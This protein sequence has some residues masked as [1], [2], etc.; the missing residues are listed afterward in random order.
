MTKCAAGAKIYVRG[1]SK[2]IKFNKLPLDLQ[3]RI[4][5]MH[6]SGEGNRNVSASLKSPNE[7]PPSPASGRSLEPLRHLLNN[8]K[9]KGLSQGG[10]QEPDGQFNRVPALL[11]REE[12]L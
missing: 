7:C 3:E 2:V 8:C 12:N 5:S 4:V 1:L 9:Q 6:R 11:C 10:A